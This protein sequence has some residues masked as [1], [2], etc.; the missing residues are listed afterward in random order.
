VA[1]VCE[2]GRRIVAVA[3][4]EPARDVK[5]GWELRAVATAPGKGGLGLEAQVWITLEIEVEKRHGERLWVWTGADLEGSPPD[6]LR[7]LARDRGCR[8]REYAAKRRGAQGP[9]DR[10]EKDLRP[11]DLPSEGRP[12]PRR[13][14]ADGGFFPRVGMN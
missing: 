8:F 1:V 5:R 11:G 10:Y 13:D 7:D 12:T 3:W 14:G 6:P 4:A 2:E 9:Q